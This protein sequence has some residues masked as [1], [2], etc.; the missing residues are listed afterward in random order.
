[1]ELSDSNTLIRSEMSIKSEQLYYKIGHID[2]A[3]NQIDW[4]EGG[5]YD[6]G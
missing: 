4:I 2:D 3:T 5:P 1:M 6:Y